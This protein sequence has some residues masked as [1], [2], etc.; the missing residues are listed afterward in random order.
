[1]RSSLACLTAIINVVYRRFNKQVSLVVVI[2]TA[3][4]RN[5]L[6]CVCARAKKPC[7]SCHPSNHGHCQNKGSLSQLN[8]FV[9]AES[10]SKL[11]IDVQQLPSFQPS[12]Q[13]SAISRSSLS[14]D[15]VIINNKSEDQVNV[16]NSSFQSPESITPRLSARDELKLPHQFTEDAKMRQAFGV[17]LTRNTG[18]DDDDTWCK[19]WKK[20]RVHKM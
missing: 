12:C 9:V 15:L 10:Q 16:N 1:M 14:D 13:L 5:A 11:Q 7:T 6:R 4:M 17:P 18:I 19:R 20:N 2:A 8:C 3:N